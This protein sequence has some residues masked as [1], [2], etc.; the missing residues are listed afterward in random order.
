M[1]SIVNINFNRRIQIYDRLVKL[2]Q[3]KENRFRYIY[4]QF[5]TGLGSTSKQA[6]TVAIESQIKHLD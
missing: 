4:T 6:K 5:N 3:G 2:L 1:M